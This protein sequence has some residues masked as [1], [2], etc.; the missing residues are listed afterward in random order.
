MSAPTP[1]QGLLHHLRNA[2]ET[3]HHLDYNLDHQWN[4]SL[5]NPATKMPEDMTT[6][7]IGRVSSPN[8]VALKK[9]NR[10]IQIIMTEH[11]E[12]RD[13]YLKRSD[14]FNNNNKVWREVHGLP[15]LE[16]SE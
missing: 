15:P 10:L 4:W 3:C 8:Q 14:E 16:E 12:L 5:T 11:M 7:E 6:E 2:R 9:I 13:D 1:F